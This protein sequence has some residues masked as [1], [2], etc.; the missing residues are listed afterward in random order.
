MAKSPRENSKTLLELVTKVYDLFFGEKR[1]E[2]KKLISQIQQDFGDLEIDQKELDQKNAAGHTSLHIAGLIRKLCGN[3]D[4]FNFL[5]DKGATLG[6]EDKVDQGFEELSVRNEP[7]TI[8]IIG[9]DVREDYLGGV[10]EKPWISVIRIDK[11]DEYNAKIAEIKLKMQEAAKQNHKAPITLVFDFHGVLKDNNFLID[12]GGRLLSFYDFLMDLD[13]KSFSQAPLI[14]QV[15]SCH[16]G[17]FIAQTDK[18]DKSESHSFNSR[19]SMLRRAIPQG[20]FLV[21][22]AGK[23]PVESNPVNRNI[24][25]LI[26]HA[27]QSLFADLVCK[28]AS[29]PQTFKAI[30][31]S[32]YG[33][34]DIFKYSYLKRESIETQV[35][36]G[37]PLLGLFKKHIQINIDNFASFY[38]RA[39]LNAQRDDLLK[40]KENAKS[41]ISEADIV[42]S[43][44]MNLVILIYKQNLQDLRYYVEFVI[45]EL[46]K[47][48]TIKDLVLDWGNLV[49]FA[50]VNEDFEIIKFLS[51]KT[52][53]IN[54]KSKYGSSP[55]HAAS[56]SGYVAAIDLLL[57]QGANIELESDNGLRPLHF[58]CYSGSGL[59]IEFL[60]EKGAN[61]HARTINDQSVFVFACNQNCHKRI[62]ELILRKA[63]EQF[64]QLTLPDVSQELTQNLQ[65]FIRDIHDIIKKSDLD[66]NIKKLLENFLQEKEQLL[67]TQEPSDWFLTDA[68]R[69]SASRVIDDQRN[70]DKTKCSP[71]NVQ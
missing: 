60:L 65:L 55:L 61:I 69:P 24:R 10:N 62:V 36:Q 22:N 15:F 47:D 34:V 58:A 56:Q 17:A 25:Q 52:S 28:I 11:P 63:S 16:S 20:C 38:L 44:K 31:K 40:Y 51:A 53:D 66:E 29:S 71:C 57:S 42:E 14:I 48:G 70:R 32:K 1:D 8:L 68:K 5:I 23:Y 26:A 3:E 39:T 54:K 4:L 59:A 41:I 27:N 67:P 45:E 37:K 64:Q 33:G 46:K 6:V 2:A 9:K 18:D 7:K 50:C 35:A 21:F 13:I 49:E 12:L 19:Q 30:H 43:I